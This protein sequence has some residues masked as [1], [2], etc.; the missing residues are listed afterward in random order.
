MILMQ[1]KALFIDAYRELNA[2]KLFWISIVLSAL[3]V[4]L[5]ASIGYDEDG[6]SF[7]WMNVSFLPFRPSIVSREFFYLEI[8]F[9]GIGIRFWLTWVITI[10]ALVSTAGVIPDLIA[11]GTIETTLSKPISRTRLF[12][13]KYCT[14]LMFV[15]LQVGAFSI[16][17]FLA[18]GIRGGVWEPNLFLAIPIVL[19]LF[20]FL[21]SVSATIGMITRAAM[22]AL[23]IT[24]LL[25]AVIFLM[26]IADA[27]L[28]M[29]K[30]NSE[31]LVEQ[32]EARIVEITE[33]TTRLIR[34]ERN[35]EEPGSGDG[36]E[37]SM[38]EIETRNQFLPQIVEGLEDDREDLRQL[39][40]WHNLIFT[41]KTVL[42]KTV[43][44]KDLLSKHLVDPSLYPERERNQVEEPEDPNT[45]VIDQAETEKRMQEEMRGRSLLWVLGTSFLFEGVLVLFC[46][47]RFNR[48][49]F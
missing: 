40:F 8:L 7:L 27:S 37:P 43:E 18:I 39:T 13:T 5:F 25:W 19:A 31:I 28:L 12:L 29:F 23:L 15:A 1:T 10:L 49:D 38:E 14:G 34:S 45:F 30:V 42:P 20:S 44:T 16:G 36:Y 9:S 21:F 35:R 32:R 22:P 24:C 26:N 41:V 48:R 2:K 46:L 3:L 33:N 47:W 11:S 6:V 17:S 4:V